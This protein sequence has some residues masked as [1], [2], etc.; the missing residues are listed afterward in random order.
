MKRYDLIIAGGG[1]AGSTVATLVKRYSPQTRVLLL[2]KAQFPR[3]HVGESLLAGASPVLQDM[4]VYDKVN[5]HGFVEKL[6]ATYVWGQDRKP[7]GFEFDEI[8]NKFAQHGQQ[9]P[10]LYCK[11]WQVQRSKYD[12]LLLNHAAAMGVEVHQNARVLRVLRNPGDER[13]VGV[14]YRDG[15]GSRCVECSWFMDCTGQ[16]AL[17]GRELKLLEYDEQMNNYALFGYWKGAKW[18]F[19]Y[20][21]HPHLTRIFI[22]TT[23]HGWIWY[24]PVGPDVVSVGLVTHRETLKQMPH[25]PENLYY[26]E[27]TT[28]AEIR[29]LLRDATLIHLEPDQGRAV[30]AI[31]DW[32]YTSRRMVGPGWAMAGDAAGFVDPILSSGVMLAHELGQKAAYTLNSSFAANSD[33]QIQSYWQFYEQTYQSYLQAYRNMAQFWYSNN[34]SMESWWWQAR[35]TLAQQES[36]LALT[37]RE[38][39]TRLT[40]GYST[41]AESLSLF[42]SYP[43]HEA[44]QLVRGLF[45]SPY[46]ANPLRSSYAQRP[47]R[48]KEDAQLTDGMYFYQGR[49]RTNRRVVSG[50]TCYLDLHP[51]EEVLVNLLDGTHTLADLDEAARELQSLEIKMP[52]RG[53][54][55]LLVQLDTIGA[56]A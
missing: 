46:D 45:G 28:C 16:Q 49:I 12:H 42:G 24:I 26:H 22:A 5:K 11:A 35:R 33:E 41:R 39:F 52:L 27:L 1:P 21:G 17:L 7:W 6:G 56:L 31:Q 44:Q 30:C 50:N 2:E 10:D 20:L 19:E 53:G 54:L 25:G 55:D 40:F 36:D 37:D 14:E 43:L 38:A 15:E 51:A 9:L 23:P 18:K 34:F 29:D 48:L 32:S 13:V 3:H 8:I 4:H 47:L